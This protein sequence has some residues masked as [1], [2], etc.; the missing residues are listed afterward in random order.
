MQRAA[1]PATPMGLPSPYR[2]ASLL[3][4]PF[5]LLEP[6]SNALTRSAM[7]FGHAFNAYTGY[8]LTPFDLSPFAKRFPMSCHYTGSN[9]IS[10]V[11]YTVLLRYIDVCKVAQLN[12]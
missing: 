11:I 7:A 3:A 4:H 5:G 1:K 10:T 2:F 6:S 9:E 8:A 12:H